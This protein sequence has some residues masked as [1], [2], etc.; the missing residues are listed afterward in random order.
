MFLRELH[1]ENL[2]AIRT[3]SVRFGAST[4]LVGENDSGKGSLLRALELVLGSSSTTPFDLTDFHQRG[5]AASRDGVLRIALTFEERAPGDWDDASH[6]ILRHAV[7]VRVPA[8]ASFDST[9]P[10]FPRRV[11]TL[12]HSAS[13]CQASPTQPCASRWSLTFVPRLR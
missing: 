3:A 11:M 6:G 9:R 12:P 8:Y 4:T 2:R 10:G 1:V 7:P 13:S 5:G